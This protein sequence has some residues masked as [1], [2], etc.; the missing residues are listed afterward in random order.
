MMQD[1]SQDS[2]S[3]ALQPA[4]A[5]R[6][7]I[8]QPALLVS[9]LA[10]LIAAGFGFYQFRMAQALKTEIDRSQAINNQVQLDLQ[11]LQTRAG[12]QQQ[13]LEAR[14]ARI[15]AHQAEV[16]NQ[17]ETL[18]TMY[19]TLT[20]ADTARTLAEIEQILTFTSQQLQL[21]G[22]IPAAQSTLSGIEQKLAQLN[23][24]ELISLRQALAKDSDALKALPA[25][26]LAGIALKLDNLA[27]TI[28][29]LPLT[30]DSFRE[31]TAPAPRTDGDP[32][33]RFA[34]E[35]WH[36]LKQLI[37]IRRM[38]Q[39]DALLLSPEQS[40]FARET[41]KLRLID[42]RTA[43]LLHD[44]TTYRADLVAVQSYLRQHFNASAPQTA[45]AQALIAQLI[46]Q[47]LAL[48]LPDLGSSLTAAR[49]ARGTAERVKP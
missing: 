29:Q 9:V 43:L 35:L 33:T 14:F 39:P 45:N 11:T 19:D 15:E 32:I 22:N 13:Q 24:P 17:Q 46:A 40:Y 4:A 3:A 5:P 25:F 36:E 42:A 31:P 26:D 20:R 12:Q 27:N 48:K 8:V 49:N 38:D 23:R 1:N 7:A 21:T 41:I 2:L 37:Q 28:D 10:L 18:S 47:P 16:H 30:I 6:R 44:E 34:A